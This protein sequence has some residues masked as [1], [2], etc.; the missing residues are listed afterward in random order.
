MLRSVYWLTVRRPSVAGWMHYE[1][2]LPTLE[3]VKINPVYTMKAYGGME[4]QL[5][6]WNA[7]ILVYGWSACAKAA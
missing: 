4:V 3:E 7:A 2:D 6:I 1:T 5:H